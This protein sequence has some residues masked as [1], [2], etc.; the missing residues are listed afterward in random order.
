MYWLTTTLPTYQVE[1]FNS[2][3][4]T[5][6]QNELLDQLKQE[7]AQ[8]ANATA[9]EVGALR[10][11]VPVPSQLLMYIHGPILN[12]NIF[13]DCWQTRAVSSMISSYAVTQNHEASVELRC[14]GFQQACGFLNRSIFQMTEKGTE[15]HFEMDAK[16]KTLQGGQEQLFN[17]IT[18]S[19]TMS[20]GLFDRVNEGYNDLRKEIQG[21]C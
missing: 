2:Q 9:E 16:V 19:M 13:E 21:K 12:R 15:Q 10:H 14:E 6:Q 11:E 4:E 1:L 7:I 5:N 18:E 3:Y 20:E 8:S 17:M